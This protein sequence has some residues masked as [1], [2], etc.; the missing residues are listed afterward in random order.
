MVNKLTE[1]RTVYDIIRLNI[2]ASDEP[3][4]TTKYGAYACHA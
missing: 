4:T 2:L 3:H 1:N